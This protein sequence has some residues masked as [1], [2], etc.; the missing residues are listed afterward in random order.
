MIHG[1]D[2]FRRYFSGMEGNYI[3]IGGAAC[4]IQFSRLAVGFRMTRD[5]DVVLCVESLTEAFGRMFWRFIT[6]GKYRVQ[7]KS[8]GTRRLYRFR[9]PALP[10]FPEMIELFS[11]RA[12]AFAPV[13]GAQ[14]TPIPMPEAVSSLSAILL[15]DD[16]YSFIHS[17]CESVDGLSVLSPEGLLVLKAKA[18]MDLDERKMR[19]EHIDSKD[20]SKH[21]NDVFRLVDVMYDDQAMELPE[22][23][24]AEMRTFAERMAGASIDVKN[25]RLASKPAEIHA[26]LRRLFGL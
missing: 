7:E 21:R 22:S 12:E 25:L 20:V 19:G 13:E 1:L 4:D 18:W 6:D 10:D 15:D 23:I 8:D 16:Y 3:L 11:R 9:Q 26:R 2:V 17:H 5:L 14:L 24:R